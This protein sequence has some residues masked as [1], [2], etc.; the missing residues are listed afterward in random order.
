GARAADT[1]ARSSRSR[2]PASSGGSAGIRRR[3]VVKATTR[4]TRT[5]KTRTR[6]ARATRTRSRAAGRWLRPPPGSLRSGR[7]RRAL[8][9]ARAR[10]PL[11]EVRGDL[12]A[13]IG[14]GAAN[15]LDV[16]AEDRPAV[17]TRP[18]VR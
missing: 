11:Q 12:A 13:G 15:G 17:A 3:V 2:R 9:V 6:E 18:L 8:D 1:T 14:I 7:G 10:C 5:K 4:K 16:R